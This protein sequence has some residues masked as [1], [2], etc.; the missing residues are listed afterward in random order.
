MVTIICRTF[1]QACANASFL[2]SDNFV[3]QAKPNAPIIEGAYYYYGASTGWS[4]T[5]NSYKLVNSG[6]D[7]YVD[8][9]FTAIVPAPKNADG[10][11]ADN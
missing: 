11:A 8:P 6:A 10:T 4:I 9:V 2:T 5:N 1:A 7:V 3:I